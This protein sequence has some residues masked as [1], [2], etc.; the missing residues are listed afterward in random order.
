ME[1]G[2]ALVIEPL[3]DLARELFFLARE[4]FLFAP[5]RNKISRELIFFIPLCE[6]KR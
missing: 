5:E 3:C 2:L 4:L 1:N 6:E